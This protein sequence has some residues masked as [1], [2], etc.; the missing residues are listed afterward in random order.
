MPLLLTRKEPQVPNYFRLDA[1]NP[2]DNSRGKQSSMHPHK[3]R[4]DSLFETAYTLRDPS[5]NR[6]GT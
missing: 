4:H 5:Q 1:G 6:R 3:S 2:F